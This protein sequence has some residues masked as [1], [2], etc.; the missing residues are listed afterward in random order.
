MPGKILGIDI[1]EDFISAVQITSGLKGLQVLSCLSLPVNKDIDLISALNELSQKMELK[2][3]TYVASIAGG[4]ISYQNLTMPFT[5][6]KKIKQTLPFEMETLIPFPIDDLLIDFN[7]IKSS[8]QSEIL[9]VYAKKALISECLE[10]LKPLGIHPDVID[11][12]PV[13]IGLW[14]L[15]QVET[16]D[17]GLLIDIGLRRITVVLF[18]E[19]RI[20][21]I[22]NMSIGDEINS[23]STF[24]GVDSPPEKLIETISKS[25]RLCV[26]NTLRPFSLHMK[27]EITPEKAF[28]T[29][30]GAQYPGIIDAISDQFG[31]PV[32]QIDVSRD[33]RIRMD[34]VLAAQWNPAL[35]DG[36]LSLT[37]RESKKGY[38][39][40]LRKGEFEIKKGFLKS[41][42]N[43]RKAGIA[44]LIILLFI[45]FDFGADYYLVKKRF[46]AAERRCADLFRQS[47]PDVQD[48]KFP[49]LQ[50]KQ[51]IEELKK[52]AVAL[53]GD[54]HKDQKVLD[55]IRDI[56]QRLTKDFDIDVASMVIDNETVRISGETD[57]FNTVNNLKSALDPS[58]YFSDVTITTAKRDKTGNRVEFE[59][60]L[61]RK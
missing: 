16:P 52:S 61:Q 40:N 29:G 57:S 21:L 41:I 39:F 42:K 30:I 54:V 53:P 11:I 24:T 15:S 37:V 49:L 19:R 51:K 3:D 23:A 25:L 58:A 50:M 13:P 59:L 26:K 18:L 56:S 7:M 20:A 34:D 28:I 32:E 4:N 31:I 60:K 35:M 38:G 22:R 45:V 5:D 48:V 10:T 8:D 36:A 9:A 46:Q 27:M 47:F 12:R 44:L 43:L 14:L 55:I 17:N 33:K 6:P 2:S 1:N